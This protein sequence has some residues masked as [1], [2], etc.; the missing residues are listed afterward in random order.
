MHRADFRVRRPSGSGG[1]PFPL[2]EHKVDN[3]DEEL[4]EIIRKDLERHANFDFDE[5]E[6]GINRPTKIWLYA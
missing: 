4:K 1:S 6:V 3:A 2:V 5:V